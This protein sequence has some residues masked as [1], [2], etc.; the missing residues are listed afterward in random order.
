MSDATN[1]IRF[2]PPGT[3]FALSGSGRRLEL[4]TSHVPISVRYSA[5]SRSTRGVSRSEAWSDFFSM[6]ALGAATRGR[7]S[8][9]RPAG[10]W[11]PQ[12]DWKAPQASRQVAWRQRSATFLNGLEVGAAVLR[13]VA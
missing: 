2:H 11:L 9:E 12:S 7:P 3:G 6:A 5:R 1:R 4:C 10:L 8:S 13:N